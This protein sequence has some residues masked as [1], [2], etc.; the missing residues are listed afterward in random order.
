MLTVAIGLAACSDSGSASS[1]AEDNAPA[2]T[3]DA[4]PSTTEQVDP[5]STITSPAPDSTPTY[6][7]ADPEFKLATLD[8]GAPVEGNDPIIARYAKGL[9]SLEGKCNDERIQLSDYA[10]TAQQLLSKAGI[11]DDSLLTILQDVDKGIPNGAPKMTCADVFAA[12]VTL[13]KSG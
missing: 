9:D 4:P 11:T 7:Q 1:N 2:E 8:A 6:T 12:Y 5:T 3:S 13:R 10:V